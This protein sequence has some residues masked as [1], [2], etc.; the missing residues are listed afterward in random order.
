MTPAPPSPSS[1]NV[2]WQLA[3][4]TLGIVVS[5]VALAANGRREANRNFHPGFTRFHRDI[6]PDTKYYPTVRELMAIARERAAGEKI[7]VIVGG[8]SILYGV[9]QPA[10]RVWSEQLQRELGPGYAVVNFAMRGAGVTDCGAV[11]AEAL[12]TEFPRQIYLANAAPTQP[13]FP[14]GTVSYR[15]VFWDAY[16]KGLLVDDAPRA[17]AIKETYR[18][19]PATFE[20]LTEQRVRSALD[21]VLSFGDVWNR[22]TFERCNTTWSSER[23]RGLDSFAPRKVYPDDEPDY[24]ASPDS[25]R[26]PGGSRFDAE[27]DFARDV[28][29]HAFTPGKNGGWEPYQPAWDQLAESIGSAIPASLRARTLI[30][31]TR[32]NP[33]YFARMTPAE[34]KRDDLA[35]TLSV[36]VWQK[37]GYEAFDCGRNYS[38][39]DYG[40][41]I[42]LSSTGGNKLAGQLASEVRRIAAKLNY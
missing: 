23:K 16:Y 26:L 22:F 34:Q 24:L 33:H 2:R 35:Y 5:I 15:F 17:A 13:S 21:S 14:D 39:G 32:N 10:G 8:N 18:S 9:G 37:A 20:G 6:A 40:D 38:A 41:R 31:L 11:V 30:V 36:Q 28:T 25:E 19:R 42:H 12:R 27:L 3:A 29:L 1:K 4:F 7:L